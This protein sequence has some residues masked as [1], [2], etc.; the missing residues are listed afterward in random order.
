MRLST[1]R[2]GSDH[3][4][5]VASAGRLPPSGAVL[6]LSGAAD[7]LCDGGS[8][9]GDGGDS[10]ASGVGNSSHDVHT[11]P[12]SFSPAF[13]GEEGRRERYNSSLSCGESSARHASACHGIDE[14][15]GTFRLK[16]DAAGSESAAATAE[17]QKGMV[18]SD[19]GVGGG[20]VVP[21]A[22]DWWVPV[23][24][25]GDIPLSLNGWSGG[26]LVVGL[27]ESTRLRTPTEKPVSATPTGARTLIPHTLSGQSTGSAGRRGGVSGT[28]GG[29]ENDG[30]REPE[31][32][33]FGV[34]TEDGRVC[35]CRVVSTADGRPAWTTTW[36]R[37]TE[38]SV[39]QR[40]I[41]PAFPRARYTN[42]KQ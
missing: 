14:E 35:C 40:F 42:Q 41:Y 13:A 20:D 25:Q 36:A 38:A 21:E 19:R 12:L 3:L 33:S 34:C 28:G 16:L 2:A 7:S 26:G 11:S 6:T 30:V 24:F 39:G 22:D 37:Q 1:Q 29:V 32:M 10:A 8:G 5:L 18:G 9:G 23:E 31:G 15:T 17:E 27:T 4:E